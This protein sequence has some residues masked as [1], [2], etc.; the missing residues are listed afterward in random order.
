LKK[1]QHIENNLSE[2][3]HE[4]INEINNKPRNLDKD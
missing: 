1:Y 2:M 3:L 4:K